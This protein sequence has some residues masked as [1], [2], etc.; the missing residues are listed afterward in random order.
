MPQIRGSAGI[1]S[2]RRCRCTQVPVAAWP[3]GNRTRSWAVERANWSY[4]SWRSDPP[5]RSRL[6]DSTAVL[7]YRDV[8]IPSEARRYTR[9]I[10]S[11][12]V[13]RHDTCEHL[14]FRHRLIEALGARR[15]ALWRGPGGRGGR[16]RGRR[17]RST[18]LATTDTAMQ[19]KGASFRRTHSHNFAAQAVFSLDGHRMETWGFEGKQEHNDSLE[20]SEVAISTE[21]Y[22]STSL[23]E[24]IVVRLCGRV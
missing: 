11:G 23:R 1:F 7:I 14:M 2:A 10:I 16:R 20:G 17:P 21:E 12:S 19:F 15:W 18:R 22:S 4:P 13:I 24:G 3:V 9:H 6:G 5:R 8:C